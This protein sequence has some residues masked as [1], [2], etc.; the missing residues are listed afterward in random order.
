MTVE[1]PEQ[2]QLLRPITTGANSAMNQSQ[3]LAKSRIHGALVLVLLLIREF[4][5]Y[6]AT[7]TKTSAPECSRSL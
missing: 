6:D 3:F 4:K 7:V 5:I 1:K 2:K